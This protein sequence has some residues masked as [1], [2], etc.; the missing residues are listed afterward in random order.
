LV[1]ID[2]I[3]IEFSIPEIYANEIKINDMIYFNHR[4]IKDEVKAKIYA[5]EPRIDMETR[6]IKVRA[7]TSNEERTLKPGMFV[8]I[9]IVLN[10]ADNALLVPSEALV[11]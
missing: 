1:D 10:S 8:N 6:T 3:K 11:P 9:K 5:I 4:A 7:V 2:P